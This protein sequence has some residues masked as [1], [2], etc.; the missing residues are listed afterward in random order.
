MILFEIRDYLRKHK[1]VSLG[2]LCE[3]FKSDEGA[4]EEMLGVWSR[5]G[6]LK[7]IQTTRLCGGCSEKKCERDRLFQ[8]IEA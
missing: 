5:K 1:N 6:K 4:M 8:W 7:T 3:Y 2:Q